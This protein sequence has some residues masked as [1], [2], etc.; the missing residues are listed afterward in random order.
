MNNRASDAI[1]KKS[2]AVAR[3]VM[4]RLLPV[5]SLML[6]LLVVVESMRD[7]EQQGA[8]KQAKTADWGA[9]IRHDF[10]DAINNK[11]DGMRAAVHIV[12]GDQRV[13]DAL[14]RKD[15]ARLMNDWRE[16]FAKLQRESK[17][18]HFNFMDRSRFVLLR[19]H[20]PKRRGDRIERFVTREAEFTGKLHWGVELGASGSLSLR[21]VEPVL[22]RGELL[23]Y[24]ELGMEIEGVLRDNSIHGKGYPIA[25]VVRKS[26]LERTQ[27]EANMR[28]QERIP[29]WDRMTEN[30]TVYASMGTVPDAFS[31]LTDETAHQGHRHDVRSHDIE[32]GGRTWDAVVI[33]LHDAIGAEIGD[34][35]ALRD[36]TLENEALQRNMI[37]TFGVATALLAALLGFVYIV[38]RQTDTGIR[39]QKAALRAREEHLAATLHSIGDGVIACDAAGCVESLN[40]VAEA[41][42]G[43]PT[44]IA[45]GRPVEEVFQI[46]HALTRVVVENPIRQVLRHGV[47]VDLANHT[48]LIARDTSEKQVADSCA[49]I[50]DASGAIIGAVLVFRDV[51]EDYEQRDALRESETRHRILFED[52]PDPYLILAHGVIIDCNQAAQRL[53]KGTRAQILGAT[54]ESISPEHQ[55]SGGDSEQVKLFHDFVISEFDRRRAESAPGN[56]DEWQFQAHTFEWVY[57]RLD[58]VDIPVEETIAAMAMGGQ[59]VLFMA[60]RDI[61]QRKQA[62]AELIATNQRLE[63]ATRIKS[64]FLANMSHE[65]RTPMNG[66]IGMTGLLLDT[67]LNAEQR[68][69]AE[70][71]RSSADSLLGLINDI[72]DF[73]KI[74]AGKL[75]L[76]VIDFDLRTML[77]EVADLLAFRAAEQQLELICHVAPE[78]PSLLQ[79]DPGR[80][81]QI[82]INLAG[83][84]LKFTH[85]GEVAITVTPESGACDGQIRL[86]FAVRDTGIGIP[87]GKVG[88][89][90]SAFTQV[91]NSTT[92]KYGGTGLGLS[93]SKRLVDMMG[94]EI[95]ID[96]VEGQG[97]TFWFVIDLP[98]Q[99]HPA[100]PVP[101]IDLQGHRILVVDDNATNRRL[102]EVLLS[103][104][105]CEP[106]LADSGQTALALLASEAA[107]G[108][109][110]DIALLDMSMPEMDGLVLGRAIRSEAHWGHLP[111]VMLTSAVHRG[112]AALATESGFAAYLTKPVKNA[113]LHHCIA[114]ALGQMQSSPSEPH[115]L[116]TR[117]TLTEQA[118]H[119]TILVA[120]DNPTNQKVVLY[121][122]TNMGHRANAVGN[123]LEAVR[124]LEQV[125]YDLVLMD[126]QMPEMDGYEAARA[127]RMPTSRVLN[128]DIP[129]I[130]LTADA[131]QGARDQA[132]AAG[133]NDYLTKPINVQALTE[134]I[135][136]WLGRRSDEAAASPAPG[137]VAETEPDAPLFDVPAM[138]ANLGGVQ[139]IA[140]MI[141]TSAMEDLPKY[142]DQLEQSVLS[143]DWK[144]AERA[145]HT[146][147]G[148]AAQIGGMALANHMKAVDAHLKSGG[149]IDIQTVESVRHDYVALSKIM[150]NWLLTTRPK[151][152]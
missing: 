130:A 66:V 80:L 108:R 33:P 43:W 110:I 28:L 56:E 149:T 126:C 125:P 23:G 4:R 20:D 101:M 119:G 112:D 86:K 29:E 42:T 99:T 70:T 24:V 67:E 65:I 11:A 5:L 22:D 57:R 90:F 26:L 14:R 59:T 115:P 117:H 150:K 17:V 127:I 146:M 74:E 40:P 124:L 37:R 34:I 1:A 71:I 73:S 89:L 87:A 49:P 147:K 51:T 38:L 35:L 113:H 134:M 46:V 9:E 13:R 50:R 15:S 131:M 143:A 109:R 52:S 118:Q 103:H 91:D 140:V 6:L 141:V 69:F 12:T 93:I 122:L 107:A 60:W 8:Q 81:R 82:L 105:H 77:E 94:G 64:E 36:V 111:L 100:P 121:M 144:T 75:D 47:A 148:L 96:S 137:K 61:T 63:A 83:N 32:S 104:W 2:T 62:E 31:A 135:K 142:I 72:L 39:R 16:T 136:L 133:M 53:L 116:I 98:R 152:S 123:G 95:G 85:A 97:S 21:V 25:V 76:E 138:L 7:W 18:T 41:L 68:E 114:L 3:P 88:Q 27:W 84:A 129:I 55:P 48:V 79:G 54:L 151:E 139:E 128:R 45:R 132:L 120:E 10:D 92:R 106:L 19:L 102:L 145:A 78:V 44:P 30:V 58:G